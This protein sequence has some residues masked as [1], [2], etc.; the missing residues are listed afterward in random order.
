MPNVRD[1][2]PRSR[3]TRVLGMRRLIAHSHLGLGKLSQRTGKRDQAQ[4]HLTTATT[5]YCEMDMRFWLEQA[6]AE[7]RELR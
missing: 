4:E 7:V 3:A 2:V 6:E 5:M 1:F